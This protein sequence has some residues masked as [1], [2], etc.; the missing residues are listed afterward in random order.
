[1]LRIFGLFMLLCGLLGPSTAQNPEGPP[2]TDVPSNPETSELGESLKDFL[3]DK[4]SS[5]KISA[6]FTNGHRYGLQVRNVRFPF[7]AIET[8]DES[9]DTKLR[10]VPEFTLSV[11]ILRYRPIT[12]LV[13]A[14]VEVDL[15]VETS[16]NGIKRITFTNCKLVPGTLEVVPENTDSSAPRSIAKEVEGH[17]KYSLQKDLPERMCSFL[18]T[19]FHHMRPR[20]TNEMIDRFLQ[21]G[22]YV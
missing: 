7:L 10:I 18:N 14:E 5:M 15:H 13:R 20:L 11:R 2:G 9:N 21:P 8:T 4:I 16:E 17:M 22:T 6:K 1:M 3:S 19:W 12:F